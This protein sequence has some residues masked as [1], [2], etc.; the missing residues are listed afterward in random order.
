MKLSQL[1]N[2]E[3]YDIEVNSRNICLHFLGSE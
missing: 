2:I 1:L 3:K